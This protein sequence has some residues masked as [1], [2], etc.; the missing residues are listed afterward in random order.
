MVYKR[1]LHGLRELFVLVSKGSS[2]DVEIGCSRR[3]SIGNVDSKELPE[4]TIESPG[5]VLVR[6]R[7]ALDSAAFILSKDFDLHMVIT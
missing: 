2:T 3:R 1:A 7:I 4:W 5:G 6:E